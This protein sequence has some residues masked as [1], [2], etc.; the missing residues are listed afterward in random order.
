M[1]SLIIPKPQPNFPHEDVNEVNARIFEQLLLDPEYI[2]NAHEL[3]EAHV[4]AFKM[5]HSTIKSLGYALYKDPLQKMA[6]SYGATIYE[7]LSTTVRPIEQ[8]FADHMHIRQKVGTLLALRDDSTS[9]IMNILDEEERFVDE[10]PVAARLVET[11]AE[12]QPSLDRR[13]IVWGA[14]LERSIDRDTLDLA[15]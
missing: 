6:F 1:E 15:A 13:L 14:A 8:R 2:F 5:G 10:S 9:A 7:A 11:A 12:F 4:V 3:A